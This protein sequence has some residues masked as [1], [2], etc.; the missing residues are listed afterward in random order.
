VQHRR[1]CK[2][3]WLWQRGV[4]SKCSLLI[5][6]SAPDR[7]VG[8]LDVLSRVNGVRLKSRKVSGVV[9]HHVRR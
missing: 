3:L 8:C 4:G 1:F 5:L 6:R 2:L 9:R 7:R